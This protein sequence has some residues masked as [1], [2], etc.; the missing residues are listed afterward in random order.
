MSNYF[1]YPT[2]ML[3]ASRA[4]WVDGLVLEGGSF[5]YE[6]HLM[7]DETELSQLKADVVIVP[8]TQQRIGPYDLVAGG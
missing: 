1:P 7:F 6:P 2:C 8:A 5:Y 4:E 3:R